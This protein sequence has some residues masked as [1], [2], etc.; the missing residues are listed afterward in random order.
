MSS[1]NLISFVIEIEIYYKRTCYIGVLVIAIK[2]ITCVNV[3][4]LDIAPRHAAKAIADFTFEFLIKKL[5]NSR[6]V[7][8]SSESDH[9]LLPN[10]DNRPEIKYLYRL[11]FM[12]CFSHNGI[13]AVSGE[14]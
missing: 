10:Q 12:P 2:L 1:D 6:T 13:I 8:R 7:C 11:L 9:A 14:A 4:L 5:T 3:S